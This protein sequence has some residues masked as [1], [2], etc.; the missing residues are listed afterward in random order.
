MKGD[1]S[2][3]FWPFWRLMRGFVEEARPRIVA[4]ENV[5]GALTSHGG[6]DFAAI[7]HALED[8]GYR[9]GSLVVDA[10][11]FVPQSRPRLFIIAVHGRCEIPGADGPSDAWHER[12]TPPSSLRNW[13]WWNPPVPPR[14]AKYFSDL[15]EENP[16]DVEWFSKEYTQQL[17][18]KMSDRN[19]AK[20]HQ[21]RRGKRRIVGGPL[22]TDPPECSASRSS[23]RRPLRMSAN[24]GGRM[25]PPDHSCC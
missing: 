25:E 1:R 8:S 2:G 9:A 21:A 6:D 24:S 13:I 11:L 15:I 18:A 14:R 17:L 5:C 7:L 4:L 3:A 22:S 19:R 23:I 10:A 16:P 20:L 12:I